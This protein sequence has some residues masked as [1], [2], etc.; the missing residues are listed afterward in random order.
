MNQIIHIGLGRSG[1]TTLKFYFRKIKNI[2]Y[3]DEKNKN[4]RRIIK[5]L[6]Y[7]F[8]GKLSKKDIDY[9]KK[10]HLISSENFL[11]PSRNLHCTIDLLKKINKKAKILFITRKPEDHLNSLFNY[12]TFKGDNFYKKK[13]FIKKKYR[14]R[15]MG[16]TS[17]LPKDY[18]EYRKIKKIIR[19]S[20]KLY[21][22]EY[23]KIFNSQTN[24][25]K[26]INYIAKLLK[27]K[28]KIMIKKKILN[29]S[30]KLNI[31]DQLNK[32]LQNFLLS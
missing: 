16:N 22:F 12:S 15:F 18:Y 17:F 10:F 2:K 9:L 1:S 25:N 6:N 29:H 31:N 28:K 11:T 30:P 4:F 14:E 26:F 13:F 20:F 23:E 27:V 19:N 21:H 3:I 24:I 32:N 7:T 5:K 8:I